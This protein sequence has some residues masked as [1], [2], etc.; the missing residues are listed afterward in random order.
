MKARVKIQ[1][2]DQIK[3]ISKDNSVGLDVSEDLKKP[4]VGPQTANASIASIHSESYQPLRFAE[5]LIDHPFVTCCVI[6]LFLV[7]SMAGI[8]LF[9]FVM[10]FV[11]F[12]KT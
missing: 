10:Y 5:F 12:Y 1:S 6:W 11:F 7:L 9:I 8:V 3:D 4:S 2:K